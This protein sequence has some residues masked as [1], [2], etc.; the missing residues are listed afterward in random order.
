MVDTK[1]MFI[2]TTMEIGGLNAPIEL[3]TPPSI[4]SII[5]TIELLTKTIF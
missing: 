2:V 5:S 4:T 1:D 3:L